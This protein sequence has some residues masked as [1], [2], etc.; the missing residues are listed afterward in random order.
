MDLGN[1]KTHTIK[2][3]KV[4]VSQ[5]ASFGDL[6]DDSTKGDFL[7]ICSENPKKSLASRCPI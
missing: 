7:R 6:P 4:T 1:P 2:L 3:Y 5:N